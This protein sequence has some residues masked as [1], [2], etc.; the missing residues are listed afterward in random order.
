MPHATSAVVLQM[1]GRGDPLAAV[2]NR[3]GRPTSDVEIARLGVVQDDRGGG[4]LGPELV[5]VG[6]LY[7]DAGS[8]QQRQ[9]LAL[10]GEVG[11]GGVAER[12][13]RAAIALLDQ[14]GPVARIEMAEAELA[15]EAL[16]DI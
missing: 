9:Q 13:A 12:V 2:R 7:A 11:A 8:V 14:L 16:V 10:V 5:L 3:R 6:E 1:V 15:A 4:L